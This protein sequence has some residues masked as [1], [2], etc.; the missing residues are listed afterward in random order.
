ML[1][2][3][4][5]VLYLFFKQDYQAHKESGFHKENCEKA[6]NFLNVEDSG[7]SIVNLMIGGRLKEKEDNREKIKT[8]FF[9]SFLCFG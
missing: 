2:A 6:E 7:K 9:N 8:I 3:L 4:F 1:T 5:F